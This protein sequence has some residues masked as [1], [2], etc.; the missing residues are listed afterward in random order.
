MKN[1]LAL[2]NMLAISPLLLGRHNCWIMEGS[3]EAR[4]APMHIN[5]ISS[6]G[7]IYIHTHRRTHTYTQTHI[8]ARTKVP[9]RDCR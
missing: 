8:V 2:F 6:P 7:T 1:A 9:L 5:T 3:M 4:V